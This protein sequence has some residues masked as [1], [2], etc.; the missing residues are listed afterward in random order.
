MIRF[1]S[2]IDKDL[3]KVIEEGPED[4][5]VLVNE[6]LGTDATPFLP[7]YRFPKPRSM[8]NA[9]QKQR[10]DD[11]RSKMERYEKKENREEGVPT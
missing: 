4:V 3:I 9:E 8:Y 5:L 6:Q 1:L 10:R 11:D 7:S 2:M